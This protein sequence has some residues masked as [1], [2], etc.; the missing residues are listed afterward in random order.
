MTG[1]SGLV[2]HLRSRYGDLL[3]SPEL[4]G[5]ITIWVRETFP[6]FMIDDQ[7]SDSGLTLKCGG[8]TIRV[9]L[10]KQHLTITTNYKTYPFKQH[11]FEY[12]DPDF[13]EKMRVVLAAA[14]QR[15]R[16]Q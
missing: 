12:S 7:P 15:E 9:E 3:M 14:I 8:E 10:L 5:A 6:G 2:Y 4:V 16:T 1:P 13:F 11:E